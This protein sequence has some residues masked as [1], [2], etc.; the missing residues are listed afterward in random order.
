[1]DR[2][3]LEQ[4][5]PKELVKFKPGFFGQEVEYIEVGDV[6]ER[7]NEGFD[8]VW[9]WE[10]LPVTGGKYYEIVGD[11]VLVVGKLSRDENF[12]THFGGSKI[13]KSRQSGEMVSFS[14]DCKAAASDALKKCA[15][16]FGVALDI[17]RSER[18]KQQETLTPER[19]LKFAD[20][21]CK[22]IGTLSFTELLRE[23]DLSFERI[24]FLKEEE[25]RNIFQHC[26]KVHK[27]HKEKGG[28]F[29]E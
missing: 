27:K 19:A 29:N 14:S 5:F 15:T 17:Y 22:L 9:T 23:K 18:P 28:E 3:V 10:L 7:L 25:A 12:K 20:E 2:N 21:C 11:E 4:P 16:L 26:K 24:G 8:G 13:T 6:I 1:M